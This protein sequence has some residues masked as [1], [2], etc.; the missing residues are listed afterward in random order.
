MQRLQPTL[1]VTFICICSGQVPAVGPVPATVTRPVDDAVL[2]K[3]SIVDRGDTTRLHRVFARAQHGEPV[4]VAVIGGSITAGASASLPDHSYGDL[5]AAWWTKRFTRS[6]INFVNAGIGATGSNYGALRASRDLLAHEP[7]FVVAEFAVNDPNNREA[8]ESLEGL[9]RQILRSPQ[10]PALLLLFTM[11]NNGQNAQ[12]W[13]AKIGKHYELPM[14]SFRDALWPEIESG[15]MKWEDVEAD[16]VH[17]NDRG[18]A[19]AAQFITEYLESV[20]REQ[21]PGSQPTAVDE[22]LPEPL[23]SDLFEHVRLFEADEIEPVSNQGWMYV[24]RDRCW[25]ADQ[26]GS[27]IEFELDGS[28]IIT[29]HYVI[30]GPMGRAAVSVDGGKSRKLEAWFEATWG[31][32]RQ[33]NELARGLPPGKHRVRFELL[34]DKHP[35]SEGHEFRIMS[36]GAAGR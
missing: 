25:K 5:M 17:P 24:A 30:R 6:R 3:R 32:Y 1:W 28:A 23:T 22:K 14:I 31:G 12:E 27:V 18:H 29:G 2:C 9:V 15:R 19:Y 13:H 8:A 36:L 11:H 33:T 4:T 35:Q 34:E 16:V 26:P 7:D 10:R 20:L 21:P